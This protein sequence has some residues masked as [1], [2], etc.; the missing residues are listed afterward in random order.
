[1]RSEYGCASTGAPP[2]AT[3]TSTASSGPSEPGVHVGRLTVGE[4][5]V[6]RVLEARDVAGVDER[7]RDVRAADPP[8]RAARDV[9]PRDRVAELVEPL[10]R[11]RSLRLPR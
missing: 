3:T 4:Q 9:L 7:R 2:L 1:M 6:E 5:A 10:A 8:L 11:S